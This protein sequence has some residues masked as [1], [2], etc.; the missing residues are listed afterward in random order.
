MFNSVKKEAK[1]CHSSVVSIGLITMT[2]KH[3]FLALSDFYI[4]ELHAIEVGRRGTKTEVISN[5]F[6]L[7]DLDDWCEKWLTWLFKK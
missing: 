3:T 4:L 2:R 5:C 7:T 1:K 6:K